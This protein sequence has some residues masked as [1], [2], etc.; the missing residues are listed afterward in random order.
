M[1]LLTKGIGFFKKFLV[2]TK[3]QV[4][5]TSS[6]FL[7]RNGFCYNTQ[8]SMT[9]IGSKN[10]QIHNFIIQKDFKCDDLYNGPKHFIKKIFDCVSIL[11]HR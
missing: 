2:L 11:N 1:F 8:P 3:I 10:P 4:V 9:N 6:I 7:Y 5:D